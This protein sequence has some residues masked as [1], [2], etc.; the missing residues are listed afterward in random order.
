MD[1]IRNVLANYDSITEHMAK[2]VNRKFSKL[3]KQLIKD[4]LVVNGN[5]KVYLYDANNDLKWSVT[6]NESGSVDYV[7]EDCM[8]HL[9]L[10]T[11][12]ANFIKGIFE[13]STLRD[14]FMINHADVYDTRE[15]YRLLGT[16]KL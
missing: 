4:Y 1:T 11:D 16:I 6:P 3:Q 2:E 5:I 15:E 13:V 8:C 7:Y 10:P 12:N 9:E 14:F